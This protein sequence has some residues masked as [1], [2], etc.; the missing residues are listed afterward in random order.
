VASDEPTLIYYNADGKRVK[1][2]DASAVRQY[3][4]DDA[5]RPDAKAIE[6]PTETKAIHAPPEDK[7]IAGP[8]EKK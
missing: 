8:T 6:A 2:G 1:E 5:A 4:S 3:L 7:A